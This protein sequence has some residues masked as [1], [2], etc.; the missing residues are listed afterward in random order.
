M[1]EGFTDFIEAGGP[2][3]ERF[4]PGSDRRFNEALTQLRIRIQQQEDE[5]SDRY[6]LTGLSLTDH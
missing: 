4:G 3:G 2:N 6:K 1:R 5:V